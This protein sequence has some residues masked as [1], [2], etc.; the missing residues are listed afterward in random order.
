MTPEQAA[1]VFEAFTQADSSTT[2]KFGGTGLGLAITKKFCEMLEGEIVVR[3]EPGKGT[4]FTVLLP[5]RARLEV[6]AAAPQPAS[7]TMSQSLPA[8]SGAGERGNVLII[9]HDPLIQNLL[10]TYLARERCTA[11]VANSAE[12]G[13]RGARMQRPD[14]IILDIAMQAVDGWNI[15]ARLKSDPELRDIPVAVLTHSDRK[16]LGF[17]LSSAAYLTKPIDLDRLASVLREH[18]PSRQGTVLVVEDDCNS[19][20]LL[21]TILVKN[22][23][24]VEVAENGRV[25]L[26]KVNVQL[27][28]MILLDL[29]MPEVDG[30][31]F[32]EEFHKQ[33]AAREVPVVVLT[34]KDLIAE[35][36]RRLHGHVERIMTKDESPEAALQSVAALIG[37]RLHGALAPSPAA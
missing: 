36:H 23:Y 13:L 35:D 17:A 24:Q 16:L 21:K 15:L 8:S 34:A 6:L 30:F 9:D 5:A 31:G 18:C 2:R 26:D 1:K 25:A 27:P 12:E 7:Q 11:R 4:V 37:H 14:M 20:D 28:R 19:R 22:G 33:P 29:T 32:L 3:S 10:K